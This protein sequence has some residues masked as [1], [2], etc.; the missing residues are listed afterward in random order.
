MI[1]RHM[2]ESL[3]YETTL[4]NPVKFKAFVDDIIGVYTNWQKTAEE[5]YKYL[6]R[7]HLIPVL[8]AAEMY[9]WT[10]RKIAKDP[11][12]IYQKKVKPSVPRIVVNYGF[13]ALTA[14]Y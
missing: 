1:D 6:P 12:I 13:N 2:L 7:K 5:G 8:N 14:A 3:D 10:A 4:S 11:F 9:K